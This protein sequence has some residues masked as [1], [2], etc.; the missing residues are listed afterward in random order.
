M[1]P[2]QRT[3]GNFCPG[4]SRAP[5][6]LP[7]VGPRRSPS[8]ASRSGVGFRWRRQRHWG[9]ARH[10]EAAGDGSLGAPYHVA[11]RRLRGESHRIGAGVRG[12]GSALAHGALPRAPDVEHATVDLPGG[13]GFEPHAVQAMIALVSLTRIDVAKP[14]GGTRGAARTFE[15]AAVPDAHRVCAAAQRPYRSQP[16]P[17]SPA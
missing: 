16:E 6:D 12:S 17:Q 8:S 5:A 9:R 7:A 15:L 10:E 14:T 13:D 11:G 2:L 3:G 1:R 4:R